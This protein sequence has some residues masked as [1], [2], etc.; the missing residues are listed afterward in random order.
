MWACCSSASPALVPN[1]DQ[2]D[3]FAE[4]G[5][6]PLNRPSPNDLLE[7]W[8]ALD[9]DRIGSVS[10]K[11][12]RSFLKTVSARW[13][14]G[15]WPR[16]S[17]SGIGSRKVLEALLSGGGNVVSARSVS[18]A[19]W[20]PPVLGVPSSV[21]LL[22]QRRFRARMDNNSSTLSGNDASALAR[23][24][25]M[26][27]KV[28]K[29]EVEKAVAE[30][31][32]P[33]ERVRFDWFVRCVGAPYAVASSSLY[34][35]SSAE[36]NEGWRDESDLPLTC[37]VIRSFAPV[38]SDCRC[39]ILNCGEAVLSSMLSLVKAANT[40]IMMSWFEFLPGLPAMRGEGKEGSLAWNDN[41]DGTLPS[42]LKA[43]AEEGVKVYILLFDTV[44][45][46]VDTA[47]LVEHAA[48]SLTRLHPNI[49]VVK[50]PG[51]TVWTWT[52]H[53]KFLV[54]DRTAAVL[55]GVD[56]TAGRW[57]RPDHPLFD[58]KGEVRPGIEL[59][60]KGLKYK[61]GIRDWWERPGEDLFENRGEQVSVRDL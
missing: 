61:N 36:L 31:N 49:H 18:S 44:D 23:G 35:N 7:P 9:V 38:R 3:L 56:W 10:V 28:S 50:H 19:L 45:I 41:P 1:A 43:K 58:P 39:E 22:L 17:E 27:V 53:Q 40:E 21:A 8:Y 47:P 48:W 55:G 57:D 2:L 24:L 37:D 52:H 26:E 33:T 6:G 25:L 54:A 16:G 32:K 60:S 34:G 29:G 4:L 30:L 42:I 11:D 12:A 13:G 15:S 14:D 5:I 46:V 59:R 51:W 20:D